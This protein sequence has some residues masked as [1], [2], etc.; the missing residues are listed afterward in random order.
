MTVLVTGAT[1]SVGSAV[2]AELRRRDVPLRVFVRDARKA[3]TLLGG[4]VEL[5]VGDFGDRGSIEVA[6]K[7]AEFLFLACANDPRQVE[8]ET[9]V[10]DAAVGA[11]VDQVVKLSALG[12]EIGSRLD[13]WDWQGRI[14]QHL[15]E[16]RLSATILR[17]HNYM[18]GLFAAA[19]SIQGAGKIFGSA[20][21]AKIP[22]IDP[23][24]V[25]AVAAVAL[26]KQG[27]EGKTYTLTGAEALTFQE[28]AR[29]LSE[30][31]G[32]EIEYV[33][34]PDEAA[35]EGLLGAGVPD[36]LAA[37]LITLFQIMREDTDP[38]I[39]DDVREV[40]EREPRRLRDFLKDH[41][42]VFGAVEG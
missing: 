38:R 17:P 12:A 31:T 2:V 41:K 35:L 22:M 23:R 4:D 37:N 13:F 19:G 20:A 32:R 3:E 5:S 36:W 26:T 29:N 25:A 8:Y 21:D 14:E 39:T 30:V 10:I 6:L 28:V 18:S 33:D 16:S 9:N 40:T 15:Q 34:L 42:V 7:D 27:H 1:G 11:G 24:D